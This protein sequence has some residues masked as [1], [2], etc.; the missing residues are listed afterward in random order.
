M[1]LVFATTTTTVTTPGGVHVLI[2]W[3]EH[4]PANDPIVAAFPQHFTD[5]PTPGL[6]ISQP[7]KLEDDEKPVE[8]AT[9][10]PGEKRTRR[11]RTDNR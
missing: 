7:L 2:R 5:D 6:R 4:W 9:A 1:K 11:T 3:G 10:A 8:Q